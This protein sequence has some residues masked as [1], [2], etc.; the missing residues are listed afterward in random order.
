MNIANQLAP[1]LYVDF[2]TDEVNL[3]GVARVRFHCIYKG[4]PLKID[5]S[6]DD[7]LSDVSVIEYS[8]YKKE[9]YAALSASVGTTHRDQFQA[10][11]AQHKAQ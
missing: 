10:W 3:A 1:D 6:A 4:E 8:G 9:D 11:Q 5:L 7:E 2:T